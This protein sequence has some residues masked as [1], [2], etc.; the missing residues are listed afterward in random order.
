MKSLLWL[1]AVF[2]AAVAL[3]ILG[4][5]DAGY[6]LFVY[7]PYRVEMSMLFFAIA[8][9]AA[10]LALYTLFR[11]LSHAIALPAHVRVFRARRRRERAHAA[12]AAALQAYYEGRYARAEK[13]AAEAGRR[14]AS[15]RCLRRAR[16]TRCATSSAATAGSSAP[17]ARAKARRRRAW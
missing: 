4:R 3:V 12:L 2:A 5:V 8:L 11:L 14:Q 7:P 10:F 1:L 16:R 15:R 13:E 17:R 9:L 6:A